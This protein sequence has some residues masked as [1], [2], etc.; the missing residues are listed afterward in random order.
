[1]N[2]RLKAWLTGELKDDELT[3]AEWAE[4]EARV[5]DAIHKK[6]AGSKNVSTFGVHGT[7]Q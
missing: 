6:K 7:L 5:F 2:E 1:M 3:E 4:L